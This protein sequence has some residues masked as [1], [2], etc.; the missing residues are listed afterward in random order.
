[1]TLENSDE[2]LTDFSEEFLEPKIFNHMSFTDVDLG[3]DS[4]S[5]WTNYSEFITRLEF[6]KSTIVSASE[7]V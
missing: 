7:N 6:S 3:R 1:M 2:C 5:F 4:L